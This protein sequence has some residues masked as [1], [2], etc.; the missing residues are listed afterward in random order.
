MK[1]LVFTSAYPN[2]I[3]PNHGV[4]VKERMNHFA[5]LDG[6]NMKVVA[7]VPYYPPVGMGW[8]RAFSRVR[9]QETIEGIE[10]HH[11]R[12]LMIPK[13][14]MSLH[15]FGMFLSALPLIAR[16]RKEF[17][18]DLISGHTVYPEA[19]A[20]VLLG[21]FCG[22]PVVVSA[23]GTDIN[24]FPKF[25]VIRQLI[26]YSLKK[27][28]RIIA[29]CR[30]LKDEMI[31][32]DIPEDKISVIPN[33]V[34]GSKFFPVPKI[35]AREKLNLPDKK[36]VLSVGSLI[37]RK[38]FDLLIKAAK[39]L[40]EEF[41]EKNL[42]L[43]IVGAEVNEGKYGEELKKITAR[44]N[45]NDF[46]NLKGEVPHQDLYL[47]YSAADLFCLASDREGWPNVL[48]ESIACRTP[49]VATA[50]WGVPEI[51]RSDKT[52]VL[53]NRDA[54]E[55]ARGLHKAF[56]RNWNHDEMAQFTKEHTWDGVARSVYNT[57]EDVL[58][59]RR[60]HGFL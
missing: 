24:L 40:V 29:V 30:A 9:R 47:W 21:A 55:I 59:K 52:G 32:L 6:C 3:W 49:A 2:N 44:L 7:P 13:V 45:M 28:D 25:P 23:R 41:D 1:V 22:K 43:V 26:K 51:I 60:R 14:G 35:E 19:F 37:P 33:G 48:M 56:N 42:Y 50:V 4:F 5:K 20:A 58:D 12:Y 18:F 34:D 38:G 8:R 27:A 39:I 15:G 46:V 54:R 11:P 57:F 53:V 31:S 17:D 10:V 16:I 36:I